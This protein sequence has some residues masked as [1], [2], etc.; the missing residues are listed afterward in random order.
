LWRNDLTAISIYFFK[1][2]KILFNQTFEKW[3]KIKKFIKELFY[4]SNRHE[5]KILREK[6]I[7]SK[8]SLIESAPS[9]EFLKTKVDLIKKTRRIQEI[10][11]HC[12]QVPLYQFYG[13]IILHLIFKMSQMCEIFLLSKLSLYKP[14]LVNFCS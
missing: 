8:Q 1:I 12:S 6:T 4:F 10:G 9:I 14:Y 7:S 5:F 3:K 11:V 2:V 13:V